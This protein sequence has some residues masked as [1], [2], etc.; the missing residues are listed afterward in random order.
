MTDLLGAGVGVDPDADDVDDEV[1]PVELL[2]QLAKDGEIAPWDI[3]IVD[4]TDKFLARLDEADLRTS[5]RA[6]FYASV[7][8]RMKSDAIAEPEEPEEPAEEPEVMPWDA[9]MDGDEP[10]PDYDPVAALESEIDRRLDR[11]RA[12][13]TPETLD[14]LVR[15]LRDAERGTWWKESR[16]YDTSES[17]RGFQRGVQ[18]LDYHADDAMRM[19]DEPT[20]ADAFGATHQEDV[21]ELIERVQGALDER[22]AKGRAEVLFAEIADV[23][24]S[25][26]RTFLGLLFLSHR[27][28]VRLTQDELFGDLWVQDA[29]GI[30]DGSEAVAD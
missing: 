25:R 16:S 8:L 7:L 24:G 28:A 23:G 29:R 5:G 1:E 9:P 11:K 19:D 3:D 18:E 27:G 15:E 6:L 21:D 4:V 13:G 30:A 2:V 14:E 10:S 26:V 20:E 22:Y 12:R 17:P